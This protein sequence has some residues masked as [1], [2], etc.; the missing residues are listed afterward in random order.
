MRKI[1]LTAL[2]CRC[3]QST[4]WLRLCSSYCRLHG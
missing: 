1:F 4:P 2:G 3:T